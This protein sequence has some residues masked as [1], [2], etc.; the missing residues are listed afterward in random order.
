MCAICDFIMIA[1]G[2]NLDRWRSRSHGSIHPNKIAVRAPCCIC[3]ICVE[4]NRQQVGDTKVC[5]DSIAASDP[6]R[7]DVAL[8][9]SSALLAVQRG[10]YDRWHSS[11]R[12]IEYL[13]ICPHD[14]AV[15]CFAVLSIALCLGR[16]ADSQPRDAHEHVAQVTECTE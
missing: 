16:T 7:S 8:L 1:D 15:Q 5:P 13:C 6:F 9:H 12:R 3:T 2:S 10:S 11:A 14:P 4:L